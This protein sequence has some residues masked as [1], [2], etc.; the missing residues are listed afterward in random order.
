MGCGASN[1][2]GAAY[3][4]N[5]PTPCMQAHAALVEASE[6]GRACGEPSAA[7]SKLREKYQRLRSAASLRLGKV[8][9]APAE[10]DGDGSVASN[11]AD[12][13]RDWMEETVRCCDDSDEEAPASSQ[14]VKTTTPEL[15]ALQIVVTQMDDRGPED[16][17]AR[18]ALFTK[19]NV[20][21]HNALLP[22]AAGDPESPARPHLFRSRFSSRSLLPSA[23]GSSQTGS[24]RTLDSPLSLRSTAGLSSV[25][26]MG[27]EGVTFLNPVR[28]GYKRGGSGELLGKAPMCDELPT[29]RKTL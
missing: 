2:A 27:A 5:Y 19:E 21:R 22:L 28:R 9:F 14:D 8:E 16:A 11:F 20:K 23:R 3:A 12:E 15:R 4:V 10:E 1:Q 25:D 18:T 6:D 29:R 24:L 13:I 17:S 26:R 7:R